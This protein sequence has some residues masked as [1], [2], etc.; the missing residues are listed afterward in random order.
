MDNAIQTNKKNAKRN[1]RSCGKNGTAL[2]P[3]RPGRKAKERDPGINHGDLI[4][5]VECFFPKFN[6]RLK[7]IVDFRWANRIIY[8][9]EVFIWL[10]LLSRLMANTA[11]RDT[12]HLQDE[13]A[14]LDNLNKLSGCNAERLPHSDT[15]KYFMERLFPKQLVKIRNWMIGRLIR[16]KVLDNMR[17]DKKLNGTRSFR[18]A[19]D[20]VHY[21][22]SSHELVHSTHRTHG[23]G[24]VDYMLIALEACIVC[25]NGARIP[26]MTEFIE[27]PEGKDYNKQDCELKAA[28]RLM[29]RIKELYPRLPI[30][31]LLDG[32]YLCE[33]IINICHKNRWGFSITVNEKTAAFLAKAERQMAANRRNRIEEDD[34]MDGRRRIIKWCNHVKYKFGETN[35][36]LNVVEMIKKN[37]KGEMEKC[38]YATT[39]FLSERSVKRV[40][41]EV[42]RSRWQIEEAFKVQKCHGLGLEKVFGTVGNAGQNYYHIVQIAYIIL[43]L[44][45]HS[46]MFRRLQHL[47]NEDRIGHTICQPMLEWYGTI[48]NLMDKFKRYVLMKPLSDIDISG[49]RLQFNTT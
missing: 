4:K 49:W 16:N 44:M 11:N 23:D 29:G 45:L 39:I 6:L 46:N 32:L 1:R 21:H 18:V 22:T 14:F 20:G 31:I 34:P 26:F 41:D 5:V 19:I 12:D 24:T 7:K 25:P 40:L 10:A 3:P 47:Q 35:V 33:D 2:C 15:L 36:D 42:C 17:T 27:N 8:Q 38:A 48:K 30:I 43:N 37:E 28:K 13:Q 9:V